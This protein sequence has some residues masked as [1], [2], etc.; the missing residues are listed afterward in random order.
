MPKE[1]RALYYLCLTN[2]QHIDNETWEYLNKLPYRYTPE[3]C[4]SSLRAALGQMKNQAIDFI[5]Q[6]LGVISEQTQS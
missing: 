5:L 6:D 3:T 4:R 1:L 2:T